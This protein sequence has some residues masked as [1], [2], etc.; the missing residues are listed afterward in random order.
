MAQLWWAL[1]KG[2][3]DDCTALAWDGYV[4]AMEMD[5]QMMVM[6]GGK[7]YAGCQTRAWRWR[8]I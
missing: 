3:C 1:E 2:R 5:M 8:S 4:D 7:L 6:T